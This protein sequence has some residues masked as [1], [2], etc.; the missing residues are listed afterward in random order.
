MTP[1]EVLLRAVS[2]SSAMSVRALAIVHIVFNI[3]LKPVATFADKCPA[4]T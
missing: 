3:V 2:C 4:L 1:I